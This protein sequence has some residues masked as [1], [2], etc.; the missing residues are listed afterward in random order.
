[1]I[2][3]PRIRPKTRVSDT[4]ER[5]ADLRRIPTMYIALTLIGLS[6][7]EIGHMPSNTIFVTDSVATKYLLE[8]AR[9]SEG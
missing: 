9:L 8:S 1:M 4:A 7:K 3:R 6:D 2:A 5:K